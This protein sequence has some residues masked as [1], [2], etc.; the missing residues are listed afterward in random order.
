MTKYLTTILLCIS[1]FASCKQGKTSAVA[2]PSKPIDSLKNIAYTDAGYKSI[3]V[4]VALCDNKYQGIIPV[5]KAIGNGQD[6]NSNLYWGNNYGV[7][8]FFKNSKDWKLISRKK[9]D[10]IRL[11]R[12]VFKHIS[13]NYYLVADAYDGQYIRNATK[14][15]LYSC[16]GQLKDTMH[17][18]KNVIGVNGNASL[19]AYIGHDGLMDFQLKELVLN[20]DGKTRDCIILACISKKYFDF[21]IRQAKANPILWTNQL[22]CPE[23]YTLHDALVGYMEKESTADI[24]M[25]AV[26][27]YSKYQNC[28]DPESK[29]ILVSG[30]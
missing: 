24:R 2:M 9:V 28:K 30:W 26:K 4:I 29:S 20:A 11:E 1:L 17:A 16:S 14:D 18:G 19:V 21:F 13:K 23:A 12:L 5:P 6:P 15:F 8:A 25:L 3:H 27:A 7:R 10:G 22:M